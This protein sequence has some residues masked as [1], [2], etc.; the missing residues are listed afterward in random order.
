M[1]DGDCVSRISGE[2][3]AEIALSGRTA[4]HL[5]VSRKQ[6]QFAQ[7]RNAQLHARATHFFGSDADALFDYAPASAKLCCVSSK[8]TLPCSKRIPRTARRWQH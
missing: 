2:E 8:L 5:V 6:F 1:S 7:R 3:A 4:Q